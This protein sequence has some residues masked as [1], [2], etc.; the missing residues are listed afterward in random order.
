MRPS[1]PACQ[2]TERIGFVGVAK[3]GLA[4]RFVK[5]RDIAVVR[6]AIHGEGRAILAA[7]GVTIVSPSA[8][9]AV[10]RILAFECRGEIAVD[11]WRFVDQFSQKGETAH[12][13]G[14]DALL[15]E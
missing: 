2:S 11:G 1:A 8:G 15:T 4:H 7:V 9:L 12:R 6:G 14:A 3:P 5:D 10:A 13:G